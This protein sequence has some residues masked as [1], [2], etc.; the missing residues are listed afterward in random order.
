MPT[1]RPT[2]WR[3]DGVRCSTT[4]R[5]PRVGTCAADDDDTIVGLAGESLP[6]AG[7]SQLAPALVF[8]TN[9]RVRAGE[10][11]TI[12]YSGSGDEEFVFPD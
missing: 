7:A 1:T 2:R 10:E 8:V 11:L 3:S 6:W 9:R 4:A 12:D 5:R